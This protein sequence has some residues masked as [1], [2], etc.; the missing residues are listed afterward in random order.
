MRRALL[1]LAVLPVLLALLVSGCSESS[2]AFGPGLHQKIRVRDAQLARGL[3]G[4]DQGGPEVSQVIRPQALVARGES[5]V[6]LRGRLGA[7]G[8]A[9]HLHAVGDPD[10]WIILPKG[11]D[12]VVADELLFAAELE[13]S[14]AI[15]SDTITLELQAADE[16]GT[17]GPIEEVEFTMSDDLPPSQL[18]FSLAWDAPVDLDLHVETP[19]GTVVGSKNINSYEPPPGQVPSPSPAPKDRSHPRP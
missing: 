4:S 12:F 17:L 9:L 6:I 2:S 3:L 10:H 19:D 14:H 13:F 11:E 8:V 18:L 1:I 16:S 7:D 5:S 15:A